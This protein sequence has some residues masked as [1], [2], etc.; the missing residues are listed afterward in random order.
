M[1]VPATSYYQDTSVTGTEFPTHEA[2][3]GQSSAHS[4]ATR[5]LAQADDRE[6][7]QH[8]RSQRDDTFRSLATEKVHAAWIA[9]PFISPLSFT[10]TPAF[11]LK[12]ANRLAVVAPVPPV[13]AKNDNSLS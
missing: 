12:F 1:P 4:L 11:V 8:R 13:Q 3:L 6:T 9:E 2:I 10:M 7:R 5:A